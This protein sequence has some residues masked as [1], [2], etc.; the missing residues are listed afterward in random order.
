MPDR[1]KSGYCDGTNRTGN[2]ACHKPW[3]FTSGIYNRIQLHSYCFDCKYPELHEIIRLPT[4]LHW[5]SRCRYHT[6]WSRL[7]WSGH[8]VCDNAGWWNSGCG[9][10]H[11]ALPDNVRCSG[12]HILPDIFLHLFL[13]VPGSLFW[14]SDPARIWNGKSSGIYIRR[15]AEGTP[16]SDSILPSAFAG[17]ISADAAVE[18]YGCSCPNW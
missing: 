3:L 15:A 17:A 4:P 13:R 5:S 1:K 12:L 18:M 2:D 7:T 10:F 16:R 8:R 6:A 9:R 11:R 14:W